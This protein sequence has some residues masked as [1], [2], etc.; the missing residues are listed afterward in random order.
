[1]FENNFTT[2]VARDKVITSGCATVRL[3]HKPAL[4][5]IGSCEF[6]L[7][8][9]SASCKQNCFLVSIKT[10]LKEIKL[11]ISIESG[12]SLTSISG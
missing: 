12:G 11:Y 6:M 10:Q 7:S 8:R 4:R 5:F 3:L 9:E 2:T 1:M